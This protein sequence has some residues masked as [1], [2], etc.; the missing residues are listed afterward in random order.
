MIFLSLG[1]EI[2]EAE[3]RDACDCTRLGTDALQAVDVAR[4]FGFSGTAKHTLN[5]K[6]LAGLIKADV[7]PIVFISLL[8]LSGIRETHALIV[9]GVGEDFVEVLDPAIGVRTLS[10][11]VFNIAWG[12]RHY[13]TIIIER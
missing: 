12:I 8:P 9:I 6:E 2:T 5:L 3:L 13:L 1:F 4:R 7:F 11:D 10:L